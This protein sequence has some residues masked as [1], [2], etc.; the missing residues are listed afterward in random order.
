MHI[1]PLEKVI[2]GS[3][4]FNEQISYWITKS[5]GVGEVIFGVIF[6]FC[7][8]NKLINYLNIAA[9][10]G[11]FATV[12]LL[13]P[14]LLFEAFNPVTTNLPIIACS[15]VLLSARKEALSK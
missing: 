5:A 10:L 11:L 15:L 8:Q 13:L 9:M 6:W 1:A 3:L 7:Y 4:G 2:T 14:H 12:A